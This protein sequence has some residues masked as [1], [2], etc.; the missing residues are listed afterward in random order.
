MLSPSVGSDLLVGSERGY[1]SIGNGNAKRLLATLGRQGSRQMTRARKLPYTVFLS[2]SSRDN[3]LARVIA[4]KF[5]AAGAKVW[6]DEMS[7]TGGDAILRGVRDGMRAADEAVV[8]VSNES[9]KSQWVAAE[10]GM[11]LVLRK[12]IT[13]LLNGVEYATMA[14][15]E[16]IKSYELNSFDKFVRELKNRIR[17]PTKTKKM[18]KRK[19]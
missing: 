8:L 11:A 19:T 3:W 2:H 18:R 14:P 12:R 9:L 10:V 6:I 4:Q 16:G 7:L 5:R 1:E 17:T 13:G 15:L